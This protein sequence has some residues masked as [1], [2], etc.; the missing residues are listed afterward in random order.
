MWTLIAR[1]IAGDADAWRAFWAAVEPRVWALTARYRLVGPLS[2]DPD[3]RRDIV[4]AVMHRLGA[5]GHRRLRAY[6]DHAARAFVAESPEAERHFAAWLATVAARVAVDHV[7]AHAAYRDRRGAADAPGSRWIAVLALDGHEPGASGLD[8]ER[9]AMALALLESAR[10]DLSAE[11]QRCLSMWL[12]GEPF[13][14][15]AERLGHADARAAERLVRS[16]LKRLR[17][18]HAGSDAAAGRGAEE[19]LS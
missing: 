8:P 15:I 10:R 16:G 19:K 18:R 12:E 1:A 14:A 2:R 3:E 7:R 6:L 17:D 4:V 13:A 5:D 11:Q 9:G